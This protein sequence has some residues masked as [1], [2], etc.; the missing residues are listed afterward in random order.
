M[1]LS[2]T[3]LVFSDSNKN[4]LSSTFNPKPYGKREED[5]YVNG[6]N[7]KRFK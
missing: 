4:I 1:I 7:M 5:E 2:V 3:M 6:F